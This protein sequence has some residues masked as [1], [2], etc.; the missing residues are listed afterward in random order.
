MNNKKI[1]WFILLFYA[2]F[3][4]SEIKTAKT[5]S[6]NN[7]QDAVNWVD[8][9][10]MIFIE[11]DN[12]IAVPESK[13]FAY[14]SKHHYFLQNMYN[15]AKQNKK[16]HMMLA[17]WYQSRRL[18]LTEDNWPEFIQ[19]LRK[20]GASI[21][22]YSHIPIQLIN[23]EPKRY[24]EL[25]ELGILFDK[26]INKQ[27]VFIIDGAKQAKKKASKNPWVSRFYMGI[28]F[29]DPFR[30]SKTILDFMKV[31]KHTPK[32]ILFIAH[33]KEK[34]ARVQ[35]EL[36][37]FKIKYKGIVYRGLEGNRYTY[38]KK[39]DAIMKLQEKYMLNQG[40]WLEDEQAE[41]A[42]QNLQKTK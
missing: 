21:Y 42:W 15:Y 40:V 12:N 29:S 23:I 30:I 1:I 19:K 41:K 35:Q 18:Q 6:S 10:T 14:G 31:T 13:F 3:A 22:G 7:M 8:D 2:N 11:I 5:L 4:F 9:N 36:K 37:R 25:K 20:K 39:S 32:K 28:V 26:Q 17:K 16:H 24:L 33:D 38:T 27:K 34:V